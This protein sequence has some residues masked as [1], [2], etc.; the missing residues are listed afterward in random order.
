MTKNKFLLTALVAATCTMSAQAQDEGFDLSS[1]RGEKQDINAVPGKKLDHHGIIVNPTPHNF[2]CDASKLI[3]MAQGVNIIDRQARFAADTQFLK[4]NK[5]GVKLTIDFG[6]KVARKAG[7]KKMV[8]G[9]YLLTASDKGISIVGYDE[10]GAFYALQ[11]MK[12]LMASPAAGG[13]MPYTTC[14]DYPD[15]PLRG[16]V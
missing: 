11:T 12:Q 15:L 3:D 9:A 8:S 10:R 13:N 1:Q 2:T 7:L 6:E 5:K 14:N 4:A 16:V